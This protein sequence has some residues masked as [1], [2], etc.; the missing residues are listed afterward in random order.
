M[1]FYTYFNCSPRYVPISIW[2]GSTTQADLS[3]GWIPSTQLT[4]VFNGAANFNHGFGTVNITFNQPYTYS[5]QENLVM[6]IY[7]AS[8][9]IL[10]PLNY[11]KCQTQ[12]ENRSRYVWS[13]NVTYNPAAPPNTSTSAQFPMTTFMI[14]VENMGQISGTVMGKGNLPLSGATVSAEDGLYTATTDALG[15]YTL[16]VP[17]GTYTVTASAAEYHSQTVEDVVVSINQPV[18]LDFTLTHTPSDDPQIPVVAT[19]LNGNYPNPFNPETT[20]S[21]SVREPGRVKLDIYNIKGQLV[22]TLVDE[23]HATGHYKLV[24]NAKDN[25][26]RSTASGVYLIRMQAPGYHKTSKMILMQ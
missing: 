3:S 13:D 16:E 14:E 23:D 17:V 2:L 21:Y 4:Q 6:M 19:A 9:A 10:F 7:K 25:R 18:T 12:G 15:A 22:K 26:G 24:Y 11:F 20:I 8:P 1:R 5:G